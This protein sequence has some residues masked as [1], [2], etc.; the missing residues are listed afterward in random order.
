MDMIGR[1]RRMKLRDPLALRE[2]AKPS[3]LALHRVKSPG[4]SGGG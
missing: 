3:G 1:G 4:S 2:I